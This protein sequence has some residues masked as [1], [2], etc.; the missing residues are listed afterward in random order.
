M[1][2]VI[3]RVMEAEAKAHRILQDARIEAERLV[4]EARRQAKANEE[5][6]RTEVRQAADKLI[7][8]AA[9]AAETEKAAQLARASAEIESSI[10]LD[11]PLRHAAVNAVVACVAGT[12]SPG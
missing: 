10:R 1:Q 12:K 3:H 11:D 9:K 2:D 7:E 6:S 5:Q 8:D 4:S